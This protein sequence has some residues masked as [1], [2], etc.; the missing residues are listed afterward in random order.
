MIKK[1]VLLSFGA[2]FISAAYKQLEIQEYPLAIILGSIGVALFLTF[3]YLTEKQIGE[4]IQ[5][6]KRKKKK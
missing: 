5:D 1:A 6:L 4:R 3:I 2:A